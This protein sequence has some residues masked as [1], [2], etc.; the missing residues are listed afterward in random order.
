[1]VSAPHLREGITLC[2]DS[3]ERVLA[4]SN[5]LPKQDYLTLKYFIVLIFLIVHRHIPDIIDKLIITY[6][7]DGRITCVIG[8]EVLKIL[9]HLTTLTS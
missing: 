5:V 1:M 6:V 3:G 2:D 7:S 8:Q 4:N 9:A